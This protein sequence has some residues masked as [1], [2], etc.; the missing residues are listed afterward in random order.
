MYLYNKNFITFI[1][2]VAFELS[3]L[4]SLLQIGTVASLLLAL[5]YLTLPSLPTL[6]I[7]AM[8]SKY[9]TEVDT[10]THPSLHLQT[11]ISLP[12]TSITLPTQPN[13]HL[14]PEVAPPTPKPLKVDIPYGPLDHSPHHTC[15]LSC[16][17]Q[18]YPTLSTH[19]SPLP[20]SLPLPHYQYT[21]PPFPWA[22][23]PTYLPIL[24]SFHTYMHSSPP[25]SPTPFHAYSILLQ[26]KFS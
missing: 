11:I 24:P 26:L 4:L 10:L 2:P 6:H 18:A 25:T 16:P 15:L 8:A 19:P 7:G 12:Q 20:P 13:H 22:N 21:P 14:Y 5:P 9:S 17:T 3:C 1:S 23:I